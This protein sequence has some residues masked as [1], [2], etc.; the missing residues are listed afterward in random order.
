MKPAQG[1]LELLDD[2]AARRLLASTEMAHLAYAWSDGTP[3]CTPIWF[4]W[5]GREVVMASPANAPKADALTDGA[6]VAVT[7]DSHTWPYAALL[8]RGRAAIDLVD[9][10]APEYRQAAVRY[11]GD[12]QGDAWCDQFPADTRML[13]VRVAPE[14]V[15]VLDFEGMRR[16]PSA[17]A[18]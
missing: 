14:W 11:L 7:V 8:I 5:S 13:R 10:V 16:L 3:R 15:G 18:T 17:I 9:G 2:E 4:H 12:E 6:A 1:S